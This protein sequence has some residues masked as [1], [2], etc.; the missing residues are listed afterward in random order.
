MLIPKKSKKLKPITIV[1]QDILADIEDISDII[2]AK[3]GIK[4]NNMEI[5]RL[6]LKTY[7]DVNNN[8]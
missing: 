3:I 8:G 7:Y 4:I 2:E 5:I 6:L 1:S